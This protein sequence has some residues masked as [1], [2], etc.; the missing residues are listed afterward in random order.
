MERNPAVTFDPLAFLEK[1]GK[2]R[3]IVHCKAKQVIFSQGSKC[4]AIFYIQSGRVKSTVVSRQGKEA[5]IAILRDADFFGEG[6]VTGQKVW[7]FTASA[8]TDCV[9]MRIEASAMVKVLHEQH[10][11]SDIFVRYLVGRSRRHE[12]DLVDQLFNSSEKR[13]ARVLLLLARY[14]KNGAVEPVLPRISQQ[15][16]AE[17]VGTTRSRVSFFMNRFRDMGFIDY[18]AQCEL[19]VHNS[20][21]NVVL[22]E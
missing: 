6:A 3:K 15:T 14:G 4:N 10:S 2:G 16:L 17:M 13:L 11:F 1:I 5:V 22:H 18:N 21:L 12:E 7:L 9:L 20:L 8:M 19:S